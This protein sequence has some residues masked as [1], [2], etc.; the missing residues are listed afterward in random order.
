LQPITTLKSKVLYKDS[1][2]IAIIKG[3]NIMAIKG[4]KNSICSI[5][6]TIWFAD[7]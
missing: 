5:C 1:N 2:I 7:L 6:S 3:S 4:S